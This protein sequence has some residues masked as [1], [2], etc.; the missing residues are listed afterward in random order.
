MA[1]CNT[2]IE[3]LSVEI[4]DDKKFEILDIL[5][6]N[7]KLLDNKILF[8][9]RT[10]K[11]SDVKFQALELLLPKV[12]QITVFDICHVLNLF[13]TPE[14]RLSIFYKFLECKLAQFT[15]SDICRILTLFTT[16]Q[17][18]LTVFDKFLEYKLEQV[19]ASDICRVLTLFT[20]K[21]SRLT[22]FDK[23][24]K[25]KIVPIDDASVLAQFL[26]NFEG[27]QL[28]I[29]EKLHKNKLLRM[30]VSDYE[31]FIQDFVIP[32]FGTKISL[33]K[34]CD[35]FGID[36]FYYSKYLKNTYET[37]LRLTPTINCMGVGGSVTASPEAK[38]IINVG[39][40]IITDN[41]MNIDTNYDYNNDKNDIINNE[42]NT[43]NFP[44]N[45]KLQND[46][47]NTICNH[48]GNLTVGQ[49]QILKI[50]TSLF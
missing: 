38:V 30:T 1:D 36:E 40:V 2:I 46:Q 22:V 27:I 21:Q 28:H 24:L 17:I 11:S 49:K 47:D 13:T 16:P 20:T 42:N 25:F 45:P 39:T 19:T 5:V 44:V 32:V 26:M 6:R 4:P 14:C 29:L 37:E 41:K 15:I 10:F 35:L 48:R 43:N 50:S 9:T 33:K 34:V 18:R 3:I 12:V 23:F 31:K 8:A 7:D